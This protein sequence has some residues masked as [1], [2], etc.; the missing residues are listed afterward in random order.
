MTTQGFRF[1]KLRQELNLTQPKLASELGLARTSISKVEGDSGNFSIDIYIKLVDLFN[2]NLTWLIA[3]KGEMF[4][5]K[6]D[7]NLDKK[8]EQK[9]AEALSKYGLTD[10]IK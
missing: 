7:N 2:V 5:S 9:V 4:N 1:K 8:V 10:I 3:G 6:E